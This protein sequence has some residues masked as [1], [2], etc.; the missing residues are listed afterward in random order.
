[1]IRAVVLVPE[2]LLQYPLNSCAAAFFGSFIRMCCTGFRENLRPDQILDQIEQRL[3]SSPA[4][5]TAGP[6]WIGV[7]VECPSAAG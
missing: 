5:K 4:S 3:G 2:I 1:M 7:S 6:T